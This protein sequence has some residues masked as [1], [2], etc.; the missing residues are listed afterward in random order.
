MKSPIERFNKDWR[1]NTAIASLC[2]RL[3]FFLSDRDNHLEHFTFAQLAVAAESHD[4]ED[5]AKALQ[6]L[7]SPKWKIF[8]QI[9]FFFDDDCVHEFTH[10][11]MVEVFKESA[12]V[13]PRTNV[14]VTNLD[15]ISVAFE[16]G[17]F[18]ATE[19]VGES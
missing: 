15:L 1:E 4:D 9:F 12:F 13:H 6:Y 7:S 18:F 8:N 16:P 3:F 14:I 2:E 10:Q 17:S 11:E 5:L 19:N